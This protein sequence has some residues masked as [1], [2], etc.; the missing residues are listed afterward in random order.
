MCHEL[1]NRDKLFHL[2]IIPT[3]PEMHMTL[4]LKQIF[5]ATDKALLIRAGTSSIS[6]K[7]Y[8]NL[9][10]KNDHKI[11]ELIGI[12]ILTPDLPRIKLI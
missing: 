5:N 1:Q 2:H 7:A 8:F 11:T 4:S 12:I 6:V 9:K 3:S 10:G